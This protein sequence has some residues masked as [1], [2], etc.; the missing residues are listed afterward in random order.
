MF[1]Q[2]KLVINVREESIEDNNLNE[3]ELP[4]TKML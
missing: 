2:H 4:V 1:E 3:W